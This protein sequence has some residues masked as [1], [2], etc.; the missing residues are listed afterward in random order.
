MKDINQVYNKLITDES[1]PYEKMGQSIIDNIHDFGLGSISKTDLEGLIFHNICNIL[2]PLY[3]DNIQK[4]DYV[5][6]QM[7]KVSHSKLRSLRVIRSAKYLNDLDYNSPENKWRI[8]AALRNVPVG[9]DDIYNGKIKISVSDPHTQNLIERMVEDNKEILDRS[10][11]NK[12]LIINAKQFLT[13]IAS[14]FGENGEDGYADAINAIKEEANELNEEITKDNI[15][16]KFKDAFAD[17]A[18]SKL[19]EIGATVATKFV[20]NKLGL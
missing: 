8:V 17:H 7:L 1:N 15:L 6:M 18:Y 14:I 3:M 11:S 19:V 2:E 13:I 12:V 16:D 9:N 20:K 5:L 4:L 10:F